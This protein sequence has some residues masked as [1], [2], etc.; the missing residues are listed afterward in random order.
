MFGGGRDQTIYFKY[1]IYSGNKKRKTKFQDSKD[2][3]SANLNYHWFQ[4]NFTA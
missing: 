3:G 4:E 2:S 1:N